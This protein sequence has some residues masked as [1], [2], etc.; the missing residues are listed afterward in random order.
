MT[1]YVISPIIE[2]DAIPLVESQNFMDQHF[3][4]LNPEGGERYIVCSFLD[5]GPTSV[6]HEIDDALSVP[7][8]L[9][10]AIW[11]RSQGAEGILVDC[12]CD[13]GVKALRTALDIPVIGP[14][15][16]AFHLAAT[17]GHR[18][19]V[20]D[21]GDDTA[22]MVEDLVARYG[23]R[24]KFAAVHGTG[25]AV[26]HIGVN[27]ETQGALYNAALR[28]VEQDH[29]DVIVL[30]CT[31]FAGMAQAI[32]A[33]LLQHENEY[34]VPV[35]DPLPLAVRTLIS[36]V[37]EGHCHSKKAFPTPGRKGLRGYD[38]PTLYDAVD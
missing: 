30:G 27:Q 10:K 32:Q 38:F 11:A 19:G 14:A 26:E 5:T 21:I 8:M 3:P 28:A 18:F 2:S 9:Q 36:F 7:G 25:I 20:V 35:I 22:P 16:T 6:E 33:R 4:E 1:I 24:D 29:A 17:L 31:G 12:M 34:R 15:E 23:L 13:P 37:R